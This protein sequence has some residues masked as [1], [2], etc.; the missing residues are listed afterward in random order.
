M[1]QSIFVTRG[2]SLPRTAT[3]MILK[4]T[5]LLLTIVFCQAGISQI[6]LN[7]CSNKNASTLL[8]EDGEYND[9]V[10]LYNAG[11][12]AV[13][14]AGYSLADNAAQP[15]MWTFPHYMLQPGQFLVVF[16]S[17]K[18]RFAAPPAVTF[19]ITDGFTPHTGWNNHAAQQTYVWDGVSN[20]VLNTCS[21]WS[22]GYTSN[23]VFNQT[24]TDY[25]ASVSS[26]IDGGDYACYSQLG[27][28]SNLRPVLRINDVIVGENTAQNCNTCYPAPYGNWYFGARMQTIYRASDLI[29]AGLTAGPIDSLAFDVAYTDPSYYDYINIQLTTTA[30]NELSFEFLNTAG[31]YFHTNFSISGTGET[32]YLFNPAGA[33]AD[34]MSIGLQSLNASIGNFPDASA[35]DV[36]FAIPTPG[37]SNNDSEPA[38]GYTLQPAF[39]LEPGFYAGPQSVSILNPNGP[40]SL[41]RYTTDGSEP[42]TNSP[43][44]DGSPL[45]IESTTV[46][47]ARAFEVNHIPGQS[48]VATYFINADHITP[49]ISISTDNANLYGP[50]GMF[51]NPFS[52]WLKSGYVEYF[53]STSAHNLLM[54]QYS[55]M[56][57][58]GGAGGSRSQPQHSFRLKLADGIFGESPMHHQVIPTVPYR[59]QYSDFYIRNGSNQYLALPYK[60]AAQCRMMSEGTHNYFSGWRPV[61]VYING[62]YH[63]LYELR[64]K[65]NSE[66]YE[67]QD[68]ASTDSLDI[69]S[70]S[71]YY[72]GIL[73]AVEGDPQH[74]WADWGYV[75]QLDATS[76]D[77][78]EQV[79]NF[80]DLENYTDYFIGE[81]FM[82]NVDW[83]YN[84]IK[85]Y[86]SNATDFKWRFALQDL[87]LGLGPNSWTDCSTDHI[88]WLM[89]NTNGNPFT[90]PWYNLMQHEPY[91]L[92]FVSRFA[93]LLNTSYSTQRLLNIEQYHYDMV[94]P[95]M[96]AYYARWA[97]PNNVPGYMQWFNDNHSIFREQLA[98]RGEQVRNHIQNQFGYASQQQITL[99]VSPAEAGYIQINTIIPDELPWSGIYFNG[100]PVTLT[101]VANP[102]Y[103]FNYWM[104]DSLLQ[105]QWHND[106]I[107][108]NLSEDDM[109]TAHF[110]GLPQPMKI[111]I[112]EINYNDEATHPAGDWI[113][114]HNSGNGTVNLTGWSITNGVNTPRFEFP[115]ATLIPPHQYIVVARDLNAFQE[116]YPDVENVIGNFDFSLPS[117]GGTIRLIDYRDSII[118][119]VTYLDTLPWP[120]VADGG[121]RTLEYAVDASSPSLPENWFAGCMFGSP[122]TAYSPC[123]DDIVI[124]EINY[125]SLAANN[126]GDWIE[127]RNTSNAI[128]D[129]SGWQL[130]D[131]KWNN[132]FTMPQGIVL[133]PGASWVI[134]QSTTLFDAVHGNVENRTGDFVFNLSSD[135]ELIRLYDA[136]EKIHFSVYYHSQA[137]WPVE[138]N[139]TGFTLE[140]NADEENIN[141]A[142][143]WFAGCIL[144]S[145]GAEF[146]PCDTTAV[147]ESRDALHPIA[148]P[149]PSGADLHIQLPAHFSTCAIKLFNLNGQCVYTDM[150]RQNN[151]VHI[152]TDAYPVGM[153]LLQIATETNHWN[154]P[155]IISH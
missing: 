146:T 132:V 19:N 26:F 154:L 22:G 90:T 131:S 128:V 8:D 85:I 75:S 36:L 46:L 135:G 30:A 111:D 79:G 139:G 88:A 63:G 112:S 44:Y 93:D 94:L 52:D 16:C 69:L 145:P 140:W 66:K 113:E 142:N 152:A 67:I 100:A 55:G 137:P 81:S 87:E 47:K 105:S 68:N 127:L 1:V 138:P 72:G 115:S 57:M 147:V 4:L 18:N 61:T 155:I 7:E 91:R 51:D 80:Y 38:D 15:A 119:E 35:L 2:F 102:G 77:Y 82:A 97:D 98:C 25:V 118:R 95:E 21:Y 136:M 32:V 42:Q 109:F 153:Y 39:S 9:W 106:T 59:Y 64:E 114:L 86:R 13:D 70:L 74:Y 124:S 17:T 34:S 11:N 143:A 43:I 27:E 3:Y 6:V 45:S 56:I 104:S 29:A 148:Y 71:Y 53:D 122:G 37:S 60:D 78:I 10:E 141:T 23:S 117:S 33:Q 123:N 144:G 28:T 62:Q 110:L 134:C 24:S 151:L 49:I 73:R 120:M 133:G 58:D 96:P 103:V 116:L 48:G 150:N 121:G 12:T 99:A 50:E 20:L 126:S 65:F 41:I 101:A 83:P 89:G 40:L 129:L 14:L 107:I 130:R 92:H 54:S 84:N 149:N 108:V 76:A 125:E 31:S 5:A